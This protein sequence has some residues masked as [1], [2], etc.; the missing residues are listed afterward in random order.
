MKCF[1]L[2]LNDCLPVK[3]LDYASPIFCHSLDRTPFFF[4]SFLSCYLHICKI[5]IFAAFLTGRILR[6][7]NQLVYFQLWKEILFIFRW[8]TDRTKRKIIEKEG[9][10]FD[11]RRKDEMASRFT[12]WLL[13]SFF[14]LEWWSGQ[15]T[16]DPLD[17]LADGSNQI[18]ICAADHIGL[19]LTKTWKNIG[20]DNF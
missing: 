14:V 6:S 8:L 12:G 11:K 3:A 17:R 19:H 5:S 15:P 1:C 7:S 18:A 10:R 2:L 20:K 4:F 16:S 13:S 9:F